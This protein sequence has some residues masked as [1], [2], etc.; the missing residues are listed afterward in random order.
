MSDDIMEMSHSSKLIFSHVVLISELRKNIQ[1]FVHD[2]VYGEE[3]RE[4]SHCRVQVKLRLLMSSMSFLLFC[5]LAPALLET[6]LATLLETLIKSFSVALMTTLS[7][8][9][10]PAFFSRPRDLL[11]NVDLWDF[12][13]RGF[14]AFFLDFE[15]IVEILLNQIQYLLCSSDFV[16]GSLVRFVLLRVVV[17]LLILLEVLSVSLIDL[18]L[19]A[20]L[21]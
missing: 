8:S 20:I 16:F 14:D 4:N 5:L 15:N 6:N 2:H 13:P 10:S 12:F 3:R 9:F 7:E 18:L 21:A 1:T 11:L 19:K 17:D